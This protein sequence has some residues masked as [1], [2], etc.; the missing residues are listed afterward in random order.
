MAFSRREFFNN[1]GFGLLLLPAFVRSPRNILRHLLFEPEGP[2]VPLKPIP[3]N[4]FTR[5]GRSLVVIVYGKDPRLMLRRAIELLGGIDRLSLRGKRVLLKPNVLN[6]RPPPT[7]T[8]PQVVTAMAEM[9]QTNGAAEVVVADGSGIIRLPTSANLTSTG[10]RAAAEAA[11]AKAMK[12]AFP[13]FAQENLPVRALPLPG[14]M[15]PDDYA[16]AHGVELFRTAWD[17]AQP[18]FSYLQIG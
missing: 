14:G 16:R 10:I 11:G 18:W 12:R 1:A 5:D 15:D 9:V 2:L 6:D 7:T 13:L 8:S 17:S 3:A 4:L